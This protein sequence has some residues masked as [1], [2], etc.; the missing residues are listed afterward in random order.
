LPFFVNQF[1]AQI[2]ARISTGWVRSGCALDTP[3]LG[4]KANYGTN[5]L[6]RTSELSTQQKL[7]RTNYFAFYALLVNMINL[8]IINNLMEN[9][10]DQARTI[11]S[12]TKRTTP[13]W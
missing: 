3:A 11:T 12:I 5:S 9:A 2:A 6:S 13:G 7:D 1:Y 10:A 8:F 4:E